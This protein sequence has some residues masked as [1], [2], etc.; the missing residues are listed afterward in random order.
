RHL[1]LGVVSFVTA[2]SFA[3]VAAS[4]GSSQVPTI[5]S[6]VSTVTGTVNI[7]NTPSV[8][9]AQQGEWRMSIDSLPPPGFI[10]TDTLYEFTWTSGER[11]TLRVLAVDRAGW[12]RVD[13][14][15]PRW[16][17]LAHARSIE[18]R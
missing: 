4:Q 16:V 18:V 17:N 12:L 10:R 13:A 6:G 7:G 15:R 8:Q 9:A 3:P 2:V 11:E 5:G 14:S 1:F